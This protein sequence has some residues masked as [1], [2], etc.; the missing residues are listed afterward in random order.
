MWFKPIIIPSFPLDGKHALPAG[1][2]HYFTP[3]SSQLLIDW[4]VIDSDKHCYEKPLLH[5][6]CIDI[7]V[8][9]KSITF[10]PSPDKVVL[11]ARQPWPS[12][13]ELP[14]N[15]RPDLANM[16][17]SKDCSKLTRKLR[18]SFIAHL[19]EHFSQYTL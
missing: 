16:L 1:A 13:V 18:N 15:L 12:R 19:Y 3:E 9:R 2:S 14:T 6:I 5:I 8:P 7:F 17:A 10:S 11:N 4:K